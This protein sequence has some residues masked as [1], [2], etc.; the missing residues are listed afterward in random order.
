MR[1]HCANLRKQNVCACE[2]VRRFNFVCADPCANIAQTFS[3]GVNL[4]AQVCA[5]LPCLRMFIVFAQCLTPCSAAGLARAAG[6]TRALQR[7]CRPEAP[8]PAGPAFVVA[9]SAVPRAEPAGTLCRRRRHRV[10]SA[11]AAV[12]AAART[13]SRPGPAGPLR[14]RR[15]RAPGAASGPA[16]AGRGPAR[17]APGPLCRRLYH[18]FLTR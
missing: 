18:F 10:A 3:L 9:A 8:G 2:P 13:R 7:P 1:K 14:H 11:A 16:G 5:V 6:V 17:G 12:A 4:F 15:R